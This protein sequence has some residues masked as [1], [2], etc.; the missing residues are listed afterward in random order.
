M[1]HDQADLPPSYDEAAASSG[2]T[3]RPSTAQAPHKAR[4]GIPPLT[5]RSMEDEGR[6]LP[7]GWIR[8]YD[9]QNHHQFFVNTNVQPP[10]SIWHHPYDDEEYMNNLDPKERQRVQGLLRVPSQAD[11]EAESSD[12]DG[13]GDHHHGKSEHNGTSPTTSGNRAGSSQPASGMT[14]FG[15]KM[16]DKMTNT[17]HEQREIQRIR[18]AEE[19]QRIYERHQHLRQAMSQAAQ[20]GEPQLVGKDKDGKDVFIEPPNAMNM[21]PGAY[22]HQ[23]YSRGPYAN[24][25]ATFL[26]PSYPYSR[27]YGRGYGGGLG[28]PLA[29]GLMGGLLLGD[30]MGGGFG[31]GMGL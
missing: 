27:P 6:P 20:T 4:N 23:P 14:R 13:Q 16:K 2:T 8:Q 18:R 21:P 29:G 24:P 9:H 15:R 10:I 5:R 22:G 1:E 12:D 31:G 11:I 28:L 17:T 26:R 30:M 25:N 3:D 19:E 7:K